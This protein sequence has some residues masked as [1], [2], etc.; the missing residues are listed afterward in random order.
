MRVCALGV[1]N[2]VRPASAVFRDEGVV[3]L[4]SR[5]PAALQ[6]HPSTNR[7]V[8]PLRLGSSVTVVLKKKGRLFLPLSCLPL[9][10]VSPSL[11]PPAWA[12]ETQ[13]TSPT[14]DDPG[15][16]TEHNFSDRRALNINT[17]RFCVLQKT[18]AC[19]KKEPEKNVSPMEFRSCHFTARSPRWRA[20]SCSSALRFVRLAPW[21]MRRPAQSPQL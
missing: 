14:D 16:I 4:P 17:P 3:L 2:H 21:S 6:P 12:A 8:S 11:S 7:C 10:L 13:N 19:R 15:S 18:L 9:S 20:T 5:N 1:S